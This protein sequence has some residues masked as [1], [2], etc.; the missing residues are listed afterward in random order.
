VPRDTSGLMPP[1]K[2]GQSGNPGG[3]P[4]KRPVTDEYFQILGETVPE[5]LRTKINRQFKQELLPPGSTW[6]RAGALR[7]A[8]DSLIEGGHMASKEMREATEGK[9]PMWLEIRGVEKREITIKVIHDRKKE[10]FKEL[11]TL[12]ISSNPSE[13]NGHS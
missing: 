2:P 3:R 8:I 5:E 11:N 1:W 12:S 13:N 9:A 7:R 6:A 4:K 10:S